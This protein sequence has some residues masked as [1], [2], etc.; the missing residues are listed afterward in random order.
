[1]EAS[2]HTSSFT[3]PLVECKVCHKRFRAD[4]KDEQAA[5]SKEHKES[6]S[7]TEPKQFNLLTEVFLGVT[8]PK[9]KAYLR[10]EITQGVFVISRMWSI[11]PRKNSVRDCANR[12]SVQE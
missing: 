1:M 4:K 2:G 6:T 3:D 5:H 7:W 11:P 8:E 12:E 9:Q 10:G